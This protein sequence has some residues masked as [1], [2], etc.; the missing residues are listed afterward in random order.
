M[1]NDTYQASGILG[2]NAPIVSVI[3]I[4]YKMRR[5]ALN[6]IQSLSVTCQK[7]VSQSD[8]E[9]IVVENSSDECLDE[10][11]VKSFGGNIHYY[12]RHEAGKSPAAAIN[13]AL[14]VAQGST[15]G[16]LIDG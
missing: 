16:L 5:Q 6:T 13:F 7:N 15:I 10:T 8:Y 9:I 1:G 14:S 3:V 4:A 11:E 12:R 2:M